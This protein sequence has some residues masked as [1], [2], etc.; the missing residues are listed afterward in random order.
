MI[1]TWSSQD[2]DSK[3]PLEKLITGQRLQPFQN[4]HQVCEQWAK[5]QAV[6]AVADYHAMKK[7]PYGLLYISTG[8]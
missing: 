2:E 4:S 1:Q 8:M 3:S 5:R 7:H 6:L